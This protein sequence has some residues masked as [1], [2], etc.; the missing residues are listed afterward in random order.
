MMEK[1]LGEYT[2][3]EMYGQPES[4]AAVL[5]SLPAIYQTLDAVFAQPYDELIF[6]GCGTSLYAAQAAAH[7]WRT[8]N[9][10]PASAVCCSELYLFPQVY[11]KGK[12]VLVVPI[13]RKS[14]TTEVRRAIDRVRKL[15]G[16]TSMAITCDPASG[17]YNDAVV[18]APDTQEESVVMTR[19]FTS[20]VLIAMIMSMYEGDCKAEISAMANY[21]QQAQ[22]LL[23]RMDAFAADIVKA[24]PET[25]LFVTLGQ[26]AYYGIANECTNKM[27][28]MSLTHAEAFHSMEYR[29][30]PMSLADGRTLVLLLAHPQ[31]LREEAELMRELKG[32]G[33]ITAVVGDEVESAMQGAADHALSLG[34]GYNACQSAPLIGLIGQFLGHHL[35]RKKNLDADTPRHLSLAIVLDDET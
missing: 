1:A 29:H 2:Y 34:L 21:A 23:T 5:R 33:A 26:G 35:A 20:M 32:Y 15:P 9:A 18:L 16:V 13:T 31:A 24:H 6:T 27:K 8:Y 12:R 17:E 25:E 11:C 19:S 4:F 10:T 28:E 22:E 14:C 3:R 30:G 7:A